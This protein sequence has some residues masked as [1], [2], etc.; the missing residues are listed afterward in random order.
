MQPPATVAA[1]NSRLSFD[2]NNWSGHA[3]FH[4]HDLR[5]NRDLVPLDSVGS[6][7]LLVRADCHRDGLIFPC[8]P[9]GIPNRRVR[10]PGKNVWYGEVESE[11]LGVMAGDMGLQCW[12]M[13]NV[14]VVHW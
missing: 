2:L 12:G 7:M 9:Y 14:R 13:P 8:F 11:G 10:P 5:G 4:L 6:A 1:H 3:Q